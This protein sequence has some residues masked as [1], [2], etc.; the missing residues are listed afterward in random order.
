[1]GCQ[2]YELFETRALCLT[3]D[4]NSSDSANWPNNLFFYFLLIILNSFIVVQLV[5]VRSGVA[6]TDPNAE[7]PLF[8]EKKRGG[9][10]SWF[11]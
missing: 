1:M 2:G 9:L 6:S 8:Y 10:F 5:R 7:Q 3:L 11:G 4:F